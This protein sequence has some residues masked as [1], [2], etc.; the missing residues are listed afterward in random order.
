VRIE[1][2]RAVNANQDTRLQTDLANLRDLDFPKAVSELQLT[3]NALQATLSSS[4]R[5][6]SGTSLLDF[7]R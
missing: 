2:A 7:L 5:L 6:M 3:D 4:S 1:A